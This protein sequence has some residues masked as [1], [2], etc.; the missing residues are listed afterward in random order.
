VMDVT[1]AMNKHSRMIVIYLGVFII[2]NIIIQKIHSIRNYLIYKINDTYQSSSTNSIA[3]SPP[4]SPSTHKI[5]ELA[6]YTFLIS[7]TL[8]LNRFLNSLKNN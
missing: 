1:V 7:K 8:K 3:I 4:K 5:S 6:N 2:I